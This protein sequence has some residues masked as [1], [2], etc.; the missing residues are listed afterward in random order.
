MIIKEDMVGFD[1]DTDKDFEFVSIGKD[2]DFALVHL[3]DADHLTTEEIADEAH[4]AIEEMKGLLAKMNS[5]TA[6]RDEKERLLSLNAKLSMVKQDMAKSSETEH[7]D[8]DVLKSRNAV[9]TNNLIQTLRNEEIEGITKGISA[10][11]SVDLAFIMDSTGS[12]QSLIDSVKANIKVIVQKIR[13]T[14][15]NLN[16]R[17]AFVA[18]RDLCD[19]NN[20]FEVMD[21]DSSIPH[22]EDFLTNLKATGGGDAAEDIVGAI[23]KANSLSWSQP[24]R[25][26]FLIAD[27]P[28]H[29]SEFN[30]GVGDDHPFGSPG[31]DIVEELNVLA[32]HPPNGSMSLI[33]GHILHHTDVMIARLQQNY[34]LDISVVPVHD[35]G[36][37]KASITSSVRKSIFKTVT[38]TKH[39]GGNASFSL[40]SN[41]EALLKTCTGKGTRVSNLRSFSLVESIP[42]LHEWKTCPPAAVS[43][44][45]N[46]KIRS[47]DALRAPLQFSILKRKKT[48]KTIHS[49]MMM[50]RAP[51]PF[52]QGETRIAF[53]G[54]LAYKNEDLHLAKSA[55]VMKVSK[56]VGEGINNREQYLKQMEVS[57]IAHYL[58][59]L[60]NEHYRENHCK[61]IHFLPVCVV[62]E[63]GILSEKSGDRRLCVEPPLP[64]GRFRKFSNNTGYWDDSIIDE[65]L[66][67]FTLWT[68]EVTKGYLMVTD[69]QGV[70]KDG[71]FYL[72]DP[73][74]LCKDI[75]RFGRTNLGEKFMNR[76]IHATKIYMSELGCS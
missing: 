53:Y 33:F 16:L 4:Q 76:C 67:R 41:P 3:P 48:E 20:Q 23:K 1:F 32:E 55:T 9:K 73:V 63:E 34:H 31:V 70:E 37:M 45:K 27:Y 58:S 49:T 52:A 75:T 44:Y 25:V 24:T 50:R 66:L 64:D 60:Y 59:G 36:Q 51:N 38:M 46:V 19:G 71:Q 13:A 12:M 74:V 10:S 14:N 39:T 56:H 2:S 69:L 18:Y 35:C 22:F 47:V 29:G 5:G 26:A 17:L 57:N 68:N 40:P 8:L 72:T 15:P 54:Q 65:T 62:E 21:F 7:R 43:V 11:E 30:G 6:S 28:C 61:L 42:S